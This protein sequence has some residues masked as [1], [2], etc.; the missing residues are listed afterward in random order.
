MKYNY[1]RLIQNAYSAHDR[2]E[3]DWGK[4]YWSRVIDQLVKNMREQ[5][6]VH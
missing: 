3:S 1:H 5:E 6:T 2:A 4:K